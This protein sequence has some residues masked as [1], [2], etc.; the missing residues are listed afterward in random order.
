L[1]ETYDLITL[2]RCG[3]DLFSQNIGAPFAAIQGFDAHIGG[4]PTNIAVAASRLGLRVRAAHGGGAGP[5]GRL[6][7][8]A[9]GRRRDR[10][11]L[12][13]AQAG[14]ED[15]A[16]H[17]RRGAARPLPAGL[18]PRQP[19][20]H[21]AGCGRCEGRA[22]CSGTR[23]AALRHGA[24]PR[25]LP[26]GDALRRGAGR[27]RP[28]S[29]PTSISICGPTSG[30]TP[31]RSARRWRGS[32]RW[33]MSSS[34]R[35]KKPTR[36]SA[37]RRRRSLPAGGW[38]RRRSTE[39]DGAI[40][41]VLAATPASTLVLKRGPRGATVHRARQAPVA[42]AGFPVTVL[43]TVGAGDAFAGGLLYGRCQGWD[44][45]PVCAWPMPAAPSW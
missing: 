45:P 44:W 29:P 12:H 8:G 41:A 23:A 30:P 38:K 40:D 31:P 3:M 34:A 42:V 36:C 16:G 32:C 20:R 10:H 17:C 27:T 18:L 37:L 43:N 9:P 35:K 15:G 5:G 2:G 28:A 26:G 1:S 14:D 11:R 6:R 13:P 21:L 7:A 19:C 25:L 39:L 22:S 24:Q 33:W 4:S